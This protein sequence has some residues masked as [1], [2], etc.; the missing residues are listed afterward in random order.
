MRKTVTLLALCLP[1]S[2]AMADD[3]SCTDAQRQLNRENT[4]IITGLY[5]NGPVKSVTT[6]RNNKKEPYGSSETTITLSPCGTVTQYEQRMYY[7][8]GPDMYHRAQ[9]KTDPDNPLHLTGSTEFR[10]HDKQVKSQTEITRMKNDK[11]QISGY[12]LLNKSD[13]HD[14]DKEKT[15]TVCFNWEN[16]RLSSI[17]EVKTDGKKAEG[18]RYLYDSQGRLSQITRGTSSSETRFTYADQPWPSVILTYT[19]SD[20]KLLTVFSAR[21]KQWDHHGNCLL[22]KNYISGYYGYSANDTP[23]QVLQTIQRYRYE[24]Y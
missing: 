8:S 13:V 12:T 15:V 16:N 10:F 7:L 11:G 4:Y 21:C 24:Y 22:Q 5:L 14:D 18:S 1:L 2:A 6:T 23:E 19:Y 3:S 20:G 9:N 17:N